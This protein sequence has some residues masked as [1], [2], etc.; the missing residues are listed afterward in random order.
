MILL[1]LHGGPTELAIDTVAAHPDH[2]VFAFVDTVRSPSTTRTGPWAALESGL[3]VAS[4]GIARRVRCE[5]AWR[6]TAAYVPRAALGAVGAALPST[7]GVFPRR[8]PLDRAMQAFIE[9]ILAAEDQATAIE[10]YAIE[11]LIIE[12]S[13]AILLDRVGEASSRRS[14]RAALR[15]RAVA[16]ITQ[17]CG[18]P[19]LNPALVA[20]EV[21]TSL[22]QLQLVFAEAGKSVA[23]EIRHQRAQ[24]ARSLLIDSRF[25]V[26]SIEQISQRAGFHSPMSLRRALDDDYGTTP[27]ALRAHRSADRDAEREPAGR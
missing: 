16:V 2:A 22:R 4:P 26:L 27:R 23:G 18:D 25:D 8:R 20:R 15:D 3:V 24:L 10:R 5:G 17:R 7:S 21:Q 11:R 9:Q 12:M 1:S 19:G 13:D 14:P 6:I